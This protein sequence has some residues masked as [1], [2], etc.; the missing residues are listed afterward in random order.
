M[1]LGEEMPVMALFMCI[2]GSDFNSGTLVTDIVFAIC[3]VLLFGRFELKTKCL[4][5]HLVETASIFLISCV[6]DF[7][8]YQVGLSGYPGP[9]YIPL[10]V[11]LAVYA[12]LQSHLTMTDRMARGATFAALFVLVVGITRKIMTAF[13]TLQTLDYGYSIPSWI[14]YACIGAA[15]LFVRRF[16]LEGFKFVPRG[17]VLLLVLVDLFGGVAGGAFFSLYDR[18]LF[19]EQSASLLEEDMQLLSSDIS[20]INLLVDACFIVLV[21]ACYLMF[22]VLARE[23]ADRTELLIT[24]KSEADNEAMMRVTRSMNENLRE[25]RHELKNHDAYMSAL[26]EAGDYGRLKVFFEDCRAINYDILHYV[27]TGNQLVDAVVNAK[28]SFAH[29]RGITLETMLAV[30]EELPFSEMDAFSLLANLLDN[31]IEGT[32]ASRTPKGTVELSIRPQ[33]DYFIFSTRN[34]CDPHKVRSNKLGGLITSKPNGEVHGYGTKVIRDIAE[35]YNG[36]ARFSVSKG[37]FCA[38]VMLA[39]PAAGKGDR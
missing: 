10:F 2:T 32:E 5:L 38:D 25:M 21:L 14:S 4:L 6:L 27:S 23:H 30:P 8:C 28:S 31:A 15:A 18:H 37:E 12:L 39:A 33:G 34:P 29:T 7:I 19:L 20:S 1:G 17:Y 13:P 9:S 36:T 24:R 26:L 3:A 35:K 22:N 16:S 11:T